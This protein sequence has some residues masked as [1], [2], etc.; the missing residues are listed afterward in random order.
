MRKRFKSMIKVIIPCQKEFLR[1]K[2]ECRKL[3]ESVQEKICDPNSFEFVINNTLFYLF[4]NDG[5]L[6]G[7]IYYFK[8]ENGKLFL[9]GFAN[10]KMHN[11]CLE[12][13]K[14]SLKWFR[15]RVYALAQNR[16][17]ALCLLKCGF[18]RLEDKTFV[19]NL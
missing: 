13:L 10:R 18:K 4:T 12:C 8:D 7:G 19:I 11:L 16:A 3:Y 1:Y 9:N 6:I 5:R 2:N 17:S 14:M 15:G